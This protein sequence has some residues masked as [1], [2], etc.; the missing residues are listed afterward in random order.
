MRVQATKTMT[1]ELNKVA[2]ASGIPYRFEYIEV[3]L[4]TYKW[5]VNYDYFEAYDYGDFDISTGKCKAIEVVY[6]SSW[7]ACPQYITTAR[8]HKVYEAGDTLES[9]INRVIEDVEI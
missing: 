4:D 7:Y 3:P 2:K 8:L 1:R 6:P 5:K 9:F